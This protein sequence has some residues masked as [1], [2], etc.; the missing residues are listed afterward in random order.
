MSRDLPVRPNLEHFRKQAK[1]LLQRLQQRDPDVQ[2]ADAQHAIAREY[3]FSSW[4]RLKAHVERESTAPPSP[5]VGSWTAD[6]SRSKLY[7]LNQLRS[8]SIGFDV[9]GAAVTIDYLMVDASGRT[10]R[11]V[12]TLIADGNEHP[13]ENR[14]GFVL[15]ARW[16]D[17]HSLEAVVSRNGEREGR[18]EYVVSPD[19]STL[20]LSASWS[21]G[22][23]QMS[24]FTRAEP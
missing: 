8:A 9:E 4:P 18:V 20:T 15:R 5:F 11:G 13:S 7:S 3:G 14:H 21:G 6:L 1:E 17:S 23:E 24:V 22:I 19:G 2:L 10:D 12:N 16:L